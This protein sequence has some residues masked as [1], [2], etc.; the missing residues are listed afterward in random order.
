ML[1]QEEKVQT[2]SDKYPTTREQFQIWYLLETQECQTSSIITWCWLKNWF[3]R[4]ETVEICS[5][6]QWT[7]TCVHTWKLYQLRIWHRWY[8][9]TRQPWTRLTQRLLG[10]PTEPLATTTKQ[11]TRQSWDTKIRLMLRLL[12]YQWVKRSFCGPLARSVLDP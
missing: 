5:P 4:N 12:N 6:R 7:I 2:C 8:T 3:L 1:K 11:S 9:G 10:R